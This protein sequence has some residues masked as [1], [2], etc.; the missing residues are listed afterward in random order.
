[1]SELQHIPGADVHPR[2][3]TSR[4]VPIVVSTLM[5]LVAMTLGWFALEL[6]LAS[7]V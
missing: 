7:V 4:L 3:S 2:S 5:V 1:M 6:F